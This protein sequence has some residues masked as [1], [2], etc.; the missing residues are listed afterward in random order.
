M[1]PLTGQPLGSRIGKRVRVPNRDDIGTVIQWG[2]NVGAPTA[3]VY[4]VIILFKESGQ[5][6]WYSED[7]VRIID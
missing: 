7:R 4:A 5:I 1:D 6:A 3:H 2:A